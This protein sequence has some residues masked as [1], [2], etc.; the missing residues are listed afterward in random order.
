[1]T[2][3]ADKFAFL[4]CFVDILTRQYKDFDHAQQP[5]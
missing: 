3:I 2:Y 5:P 1:M 4:C